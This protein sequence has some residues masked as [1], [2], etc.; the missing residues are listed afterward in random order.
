MNEVVAKLVPNS[1][2]TRKFDFT[3]VSASYSERLFSQPIQ[4]SCA[5]CRAKQMVRRRPIERVTFSSDIRRRTVGSQEGGSHEV[6]VVNPDE[7]EKGEEQEWSELVW[8]KN[9]DEQNVFCLHGALQFFDAGVS[10]VK[11]EYD[12]HN[13]L[14]QKITARM[15]NGEYPIFVTAGDGRHVRV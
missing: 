2:P 10:I 11:E 8:G 6:G 13:H 4:E 12:A 15:N 9:R 14:L 1:Q 5:N 3:P 7:V